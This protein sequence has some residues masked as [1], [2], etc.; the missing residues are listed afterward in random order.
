MWRIFDDG[1]VVINSRL[2]IEKN[3][4]DIASFKRFK[5]NFEGHFDFV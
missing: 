5:K 3:E 1:Y 4:E 2:L